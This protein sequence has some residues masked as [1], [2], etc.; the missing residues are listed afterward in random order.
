VSGFAAAVT[1]LT[2]V[3]LPVT[4]PS[5]SMLPWFPVVGALLGLLAAAVY[6]IASLVLAPLLAAALAVATTMVLT[7]A[8]HEDGLADAADAWGGASSRDE[9]L[10][11]L[12]DPTHGTFGV[13]AIVLSVVVRVAAL[14]SLAPAIAVAVLPAVHAI[15][16]G[17]T[18][19]LLRTTPPARDDGLAR[20]VMTDTSPI[21]TALAIV[22]TAVLG[23]GLLGPWFVAAAAVAVAAGWLVRWLA[24]RRIGG[25]TGDV[26]GA[27][28]QL[29]EGCLLILFA[30]ATLA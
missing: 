27:A 25:M 22:V 15:S 4:T 8:L 29:A 20:A 11:I 14:A 13:L 19:G 17:L 30:A 10:R 12:R 2:R 28:E 3:P 23:I 18:V 9:A 6:V 7:G 21:S 26:L 16:R 1:F 5:P 24:M